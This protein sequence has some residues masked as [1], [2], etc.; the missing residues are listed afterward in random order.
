[1]EDNINLSENPEIKEALAK[2]EEKEREEAAKIPKAEEKHKTSG[3]TTWL[4]SHSFGLVKDEIYAEYILLAFAIA[5]VLVSLYLFFGN[6]E[7][8]A[9]P[10]PPPTPGINI[11]KI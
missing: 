7:S 4:I 9:L 5:S 1:M 8:P 3:M 2:F 11:A 10:P 6:G